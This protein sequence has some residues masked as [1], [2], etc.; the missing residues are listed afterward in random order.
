MRTTASEWNERYSSSNQVWSGQPNGLL[1][2]EVEGLAPGTA[3]DVGAG[4]GA[5]AV[6][7]ATRGWQV[8]AVDIS[9][10][11]IDRARKA[12]DAAGASVDWRVGDIAEVAGQFD[13]V[14]AFYPVVPKEGEMFA[15]ICDRVAPGGTLLFVHHVPG[16]GHTE[17]GHPEHGHP[18]AGGPE[19]GHQEHGAHGHAHEPGHR[20]PDFEMFMTPADARAALGHG[21]EVVKDEVVDRHVDGGA[22][23]HHR[24]DGLLRAVKRGR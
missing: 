16:Y 23:A 6:W 7:L 20:G 19:R 9:S 18:Q 12:A 10:V 4:E 14:T 8:T 2:R 22:G 24:F 5:D 13:L 3:L 15:R 11:A 1:L 17:H 21:W